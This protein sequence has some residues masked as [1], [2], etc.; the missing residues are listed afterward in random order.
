MKAHAQ[1]L[2]E[3]SRVF[4]SLEDEKE[5]LMVLKDLFTPQEIESLAERWALIQEL[6]KGTPQRAIAKEL[7]ISISKIT[8]GSRM[9]K[10][11][12]G[13]FEMLLKRLHVKQGKMKVSAA[14]EKHA[15]K[16]GEAGKKG[17]WSLFRR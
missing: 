14:E 1:H 9:L 10:F 2:K 13:G 4:A 6:H 3:L 17:R 5:A 12:A 7:G 11:G 8:R 15:A 16:A